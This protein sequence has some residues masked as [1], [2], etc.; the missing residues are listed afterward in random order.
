MRRLAVLAM[1]WPVATWA[2]AYDYYECAAA[3]GSVS[4]SVERC[5]KGERQRRLSDDTPPAN[6]ALGQAVGGTVRLE[7][8]R[9]GHFYATAAINGVPVKV[10]VDTGATTVSIAPKAALRIG[11]D[12]TRARPVKSMTAN[13]VAP[14]RAVVLKTV[15]LGG[16]SVRNVAGLVMSQ[17][18]E[19]DVEVLLGM[20]FLK[21]FE[22]HADGYVMTLRPK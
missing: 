5:G 9:G 6:H 15:E 1:W 19:P 16:N 8:G 22:V 7:S 18:M 2:G 10:V 20:S 11:L 14:A 13:G 17:D 21:H 3:D 12:T 4:F